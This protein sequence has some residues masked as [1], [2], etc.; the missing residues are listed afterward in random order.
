M[1]KNILALS[2]PFLLLFFGCGTTE[3]TDDS[4]NAGQ[5]KGTV[6][7]SAVEVLE[8]VATGKVEPENEII[9]LASTAGGV[10]TNVF[11]TDGEKV[12]QGELLVQL[13][14]DVEQLKIN[15]LKSQVQSQ[16]VQIGI[17]KGR[18]KE[19]LF[20]VDNKKRLLTKTENLVQKGAETQQSL[21]DLDTEVKTLEAGIEQLKAGIEYA[22]A[23]L[24]E[25][26]ELLKAAQNDITKKQLKSPYTGIILDMKVNKGAAVNQYSTYAEVAPEGNNIVR[27]EVDE[28]FCQNLKLG[29]KVAIRYFGTEKNI[30]E[31]EIKMVSP[32]LKKKSLFSEKASDQED[33]R[34]REIKISLNENSELII[35]S[36]VECIIKI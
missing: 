20:K 25:V 7:P 1:K 35:N 5:T 2:L 3:T 27:A 28:L 8:I 30:A 29:Q 34:V 36:K 16:M 12:Q 22:N 15:Q 24:N 31:G 17:E 18:L 32:Y 21:D 19:A 4:K 6:N 26:N 14:D 11:K 9:S 10:I 23:K 13:D 33:R